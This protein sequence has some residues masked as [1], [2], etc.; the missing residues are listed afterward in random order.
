MADCLSGAEAILPFFLLLLLCVCVFVL[1]HRPA[2]RFLISFSLFCY[3]SSPVGWRPP[4]SI[5][6]SWWVLG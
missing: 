6:L 5:T 1:I 3:P 2:V 4:L